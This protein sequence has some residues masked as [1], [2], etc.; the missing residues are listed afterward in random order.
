M[1]FVHVFVHIVMFIING[2]P[3]L[4]YIYNPMSD[5]WCW[6]I[7]LHLGI[8]LNHYLGVNVGT[9]S[10]TMDPLGMVIIIGIYDDYI[11]YIWYMDIYPI[12]IYIYIYAL[13]MDPQ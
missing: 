10:S 6:T 8:I 7:D 2:L 9:Y 4:Y 5:P 12:D 1:F 11:W 13:S 3:W